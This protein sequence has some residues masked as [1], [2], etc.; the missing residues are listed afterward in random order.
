MPL[1][2]YNHTFMN[3]ANLFPPM[4]ILVQTFFIKK[5]CFVLLFSIIFIQVK[6]G[7]LFNNFTYFCYMYVNSVR[8][9][10]DKK[11]F[12]KNFTLNFTQMIFVFIFSCYKDKF[13]CISS[14]VSALYFFLRRAIFLFSEFICISAK[15]F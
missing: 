8:K 3:S 14:M 12:G 7:A 11:S 5:F 4:N 9:N 10:N 1:I 13:T 2:T 15:F 6:S